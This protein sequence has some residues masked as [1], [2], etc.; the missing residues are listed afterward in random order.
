VIGICL[1][2][3]LK[4][5]ASLS[6]DQRG[7]NAFALR[8]HGAGKPYWG[9]PAVGSYSKVDRILYRYLPREQRAKLRAS[10]CVTDV[11]DGT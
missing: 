4:G 8:G 7:L 6:Q 1:A 9:L 5:R 3:A 2:V 10:A 11:T